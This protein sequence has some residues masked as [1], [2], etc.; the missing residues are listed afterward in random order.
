MHYFHYKDDRLCCEDVPIDAICDEFGTPVFVY[1]KATLQRHFDVFKAP[2]RT[3]DHLICFSVKACSNLSVIKLFADMGSGVDIVSGGELFRSLKA[4]V[5]PSKIVYSGV[6]KKVSEIDEALA[7]GI[8]LFNVESEEELAAIDQRARGMGKKA[9]VALRINPDVDPKTHPHI[10]TG[11]RENKFGIEMARAVVIYR[12]AKD[13]AG[14]DPVGVDCHI[15]SQLTQIG[16]IIEAVARLKHLIGALAAEGIPI[17]Y[18]DIGGG[19]G[20]PYHDEEPPPPSEYGA[21]ICGLV[22]DM[23]LTLILE[24]GRVLVGNAGILVTQVLY[25]KH[26]PD[27]AFVI[28]DAAMNDL[29]RPTLYK[30]HHEVWPVK[31]A[32]SHDPREKIVADLVGPICESGDFFARHREMDPVQSGELLALMSA[33]AYGFSMSSNYNSRP[34]ACEVL[35]DGPEYF[36]IRK[37]E[38]YEDLIRGEEIPRTLFRP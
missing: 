27:K 6:G 26:G 11:L 25:R 35:V 14:I 34:R 20:I 21:Q 24:P 4:G 23:G 22:S 30:A 9:Q 38:A 18:L 16:P 32:S 37:R 29:M 33:G 3:L 1:S 15:G 12:A 10:T 2:F 17:R 5:D 13:M 36:L 8:L 28:V 19:L 7:A 31:K